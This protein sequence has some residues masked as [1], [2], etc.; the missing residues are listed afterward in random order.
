MLG[1]GDRFLIS[2]ES[3]IASSQNGFALVQMKIDQL[4]V[5]LVCVCRLGEPDDSDNPEKLWTDLETKVLKVRGAVY[6]T[7]L[8]RQRAFSP[9]RHCTSLRSVAG[10]DYKRRWDS[11]GS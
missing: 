11:T 8:E 2:W 10:I 6:E 1:D 9:R 7:H 5:I 3:L 4:C